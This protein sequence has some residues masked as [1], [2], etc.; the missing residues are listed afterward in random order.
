MQERKG[1]NK[2]EKWI[3]RR[4]SDKNAEGEKRQTFHRKRY[5]HA[6]IQPSHYRAAG[7]SVLYRVTAGVRR[8][9]QTTHRCTQRKVQPATATIFSH[10]LYVTHRSILH[11]PPMTRGSRTCSLNGIFLRRCICCLS[12][13]Y[14]SVR[15]SSQVYMHQLVRLIYDRVNQAELSSA[16]RGG[17]GWPILA[18]LL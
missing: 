6:A 18:G 4:D 17:N 13:S 8:S 9:F 7:C 10:N 12:L 15:D 5:N 16:K 11:S 14:T 1:S 2:R 3:K